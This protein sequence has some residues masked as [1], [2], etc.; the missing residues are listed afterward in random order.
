MTTKYPM[1]EPLSHHELR[2]AHA[3]GAEIEAI[4]DIDWVYTSTPLWDKNTEYRIKPDC[5][6]AIA[7]IAELGGDEMAD[8]YLAWLNGAE[9]GVDDE[10]LSCYPTND[11]DDQ[12]QHFI[13]LLKDSKR[14]G[15]VLYLKK[16]KVKQVLWVGKGCFDGTLEEWCDVGNVPVNTDLMDNLD[17]VWHK[18]PSCNREVEV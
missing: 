7:K 3:V 1:P 17:T 14:Y 12:F 2:I 16:K 6:Y 15:K 13:S 11:L 10:S 4:Y 5:Q 18:V 8:I 9:I